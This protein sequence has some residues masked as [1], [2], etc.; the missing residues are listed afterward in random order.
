MKKRK[1]IKTF[2]ILSKKIKMNRKKIEHLYKLRKT[3]I[4]KNVKNRQKNKV[5]KKSR[6]RKQLG[7]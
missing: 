1:Q 5:D 3:R 6:K 2:W 7:Q 4:N